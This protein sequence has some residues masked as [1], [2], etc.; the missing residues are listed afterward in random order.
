ML[1]KSQPFLIVLLCLFAGLLALQLT[2]G[3]RLP[4]IVL[5]D[6]QSRL[7]P[8]SLKESKVV[9]IEARVSHNVDPAKFGQQLQRL[10]AL[11]AS[12]IVV[13]TR[14]RSYWDR[15]R[16]LSTSPNMPPFVL[17]TPF[18]PVNTTEPAAQGV[19]CPPSLTAGFHLQLPRR[20]AGG[21]ALCFQHALVP[22]GTEGA[23][24][25]LWLNFPQG[26]SYLPT[27]SISQLEQGLIPRTEVTGKTVVLAPDA[28]AFGSVAL[29]GH[30]PSEGIREARWQALAL[31]NLLQQ[32]GLSQWPAWLTV[33]I[34]GLLL[35]ALLMGLQWLS[36]IP[37]LFLLLLLGSLTLLAGWFSLHYLQSLM[38]QSLLLLASLL[39]FLAAVQLR[40]QREED[41]LVSVTDALHQTLNTRLNPPDFYGTDQP[42]Q[43]IIVFV[44]QQFRL[45]RSIFLE[46]IP[47]DHRL[48]AIASLNCQITD[49]H[50]MRRDYERTPYSSA[51]AADGP[52]LLEQHYLQQGDEDEQQYLVPLMLGGEVLGFWAFSVS[53]ESALSASSLDT[54]RQFASEISELLY[55]RREWQRSVQR[56]SGVLS[57]MLRF[58]AGLTPHRQL[59]QLVALIIKRHRSSL[60]VFNELSAAAL[61]YD[62]FG[63][64]VQT[65]LRLEAL[66]K[67]W[68]M[69]FYQMTALDVLTRV[70]GMD[71][72]QARDTMQ[73]VTL[74]KE[75]LTLLARYP[76]R[77]EGSLVEIKPLLF[78][79][80]TDPSE[81]A[82]IPFSIQGILFEFQVNSRYGQ[83]QDLTR[84]LFDASHYQIRNHLESASLAQALAAEQ[85]PDEPKA[86]LA[87][88]EEQLQSALSKLNQVGDN[89][90][91]MLSHDNSQLFPLNILTA[92]K[93]AQARL[94]SQVQARGITLDNRFPPLAPLAWGS[95][96][97][98]AVIL[99]DILAVLL[100]DA[101]SR[102]RLVFQ[103]QQ[104][105]EN[106]ERLVRLT[107]TNQGYGVPQENL[108]DPA[109]SRSLMSDPLDRL[110]QHQAVLEDWQG[111][112]WIESELGRGFCITL[113]MRSD[114]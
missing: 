42:W 23:A 76:E 104:L 91:K 22:E 100:Q 43:Q 46:R 11:G 8:Y 95:P 40:R 28:T 81:E 79:Q 36:L 50:E 83:L 30:F 52:L 37:S 39:G 24:G 29:P 18:D 33:V 90:V 51:I 60:E 66:A 25:G 114:V 61:V 34:L 75:R 45:A 74:R 69:P 70:C 14:N 5:Q 107:C 4:D 72:S 49:I 41:S 20:P 87:Q 12:N 54:L 64:V 86:L 13:L 85:L 62:L 3:L 68:D 47:G 63:Q 59:S 6:L 89:L 88:S 102:T 77:A 109:P 31:D 105:E 99:D 44:N 94:S 113:Q 16:A 21:D 92:L 111:K 65:N 110:R 15:F 58:E 1:S 78:S 10:S 97:L 98:L 56:D 48:K 106:G 26:D 17:P 2:G 19:I 108:L 67:D 9:L 55:H 35:V 93:Q 84:D 73:R 57:R 7:Q 80:N 53:R 101:G 32:D 112:L 96:G 71:Q 38:P 27:L 103:V 82:Q